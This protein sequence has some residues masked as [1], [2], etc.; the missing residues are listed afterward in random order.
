MSVSGALHPVD[1]VWCPLPTGVRRSDDRGVTPRFLDHVAACVRRALTEQAG[2]VL[3]FVPGVAEVSGTVRRLGGSDA[4]VLPLHGRLTS[5]EQD[6]ALTP[7]P[8]RRV[9]VSTAVAE[10]SLT[11]PGCARSSTPG[12]PANRAPTTAAAWPGS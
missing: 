10:S 3:V 9:V 7:G 5:S 11:V 12:S 8:R 1:E 2:D 6:R 4:D